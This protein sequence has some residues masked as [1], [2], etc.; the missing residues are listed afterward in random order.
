MLLITAIPRKY[1]KEAKNQKQAVT[2]DLEPFNRM[3]SILGDN[4]LAKMYGRG[5]R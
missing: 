1:I 5:G 2:L 4:G 3:E